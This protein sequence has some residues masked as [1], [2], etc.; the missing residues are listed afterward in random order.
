MKLSNAS[1]SGKAHKKFR[2]QKL[3]E[4]KAK[5]AT[6][7]LETGKLWEVNIQWAEKYALLK[8]ESTQKEIQLGKKDDIINTLMGEVEKGSDDNLQNLEKNK[9]TLV[10]MMKINMPYDYLENKYMNT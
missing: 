1:L 5:Y 2:S 4:L 7:K 3:I 6:L 8:E 10:N 9:Q